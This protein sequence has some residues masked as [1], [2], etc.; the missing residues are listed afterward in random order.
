MI[1]ACCGSGN[2]IIHALELGFKPE[3]IYGYDIDPVAIEITNA[4]VFKVTGY[5][6]DNIKMGDFL[7]IAS[8]QEP[9]KFDYIYTNPPWGK[10]LPKEERVSFGM[11]FA[12]GASID[13]CSL[14]FFAC[15]ECLNG[16]GKLGLLLPESFFNIA[17]FESARLKSLQLAIERLVDYGKAFKGLVTQAQAIV[18]RNTPAGFNHKVKCESLNNCFERS[19]YSFSCNPKEILNLYCGDKDVRTLEHLMSIPFITLANRGSWGLGIVTGNNKK[20]V[21]PMSESGYIPV[22]KGADISQNKLKEANSFIPSTLTLYQQ[23]APL[24]LFKAKEK[25]IYKFISSRLCFFYDTEQRF[26]LNSANMLIPEKSFPISTKVLGEL[27]SSDFMNWVFSRIFN[28][29]KILRGDLESLPN[30]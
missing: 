9:P 21:K 19:I 16:S 2:F 10:K 30:S 4:R 13:T 11:R 22:F 14:F 1:P 5:T 6:S 24:P 3:N 8:S 7:R 25:L 20:F 26:I 15:L 29:H 17:S 27:L 18:I 23:V 12:A 28:T